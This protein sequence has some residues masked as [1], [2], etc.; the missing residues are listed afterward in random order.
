VDFGSWIRRLVGLDRPEEDVAQHE[1]YGR[2]D[3]GAEKD[4]QLLLRTGWAP[5]GSEP[6]GAERETLDPPTDRH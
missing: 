5:H 3:P 4:K 2:L 1:E 6:A